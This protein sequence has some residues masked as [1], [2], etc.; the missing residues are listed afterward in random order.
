MRKNEQQQR[1]ERRQQERIDPR[2]RL[3]TPQQ[4]LHDAVTLIDHVRFDQ[5][6]CSR[7]RFSADH[8]PVITVGGSYPGFLSAF[9]RV[10]FPHVV[11][12]AYAASAPMAFYAQTVDR[13]A[14]YDHITHVADLTLPGCARAVRDSLLTVRNSILGSDDVDPEDGDFLHSAAVGVCPGTVPDYIR[15]C[16][17]SGDDGDDGDEDVI[18]DDDGDDDARKRRMKLRMA[19]ELMMVVGYTFANDN[20]ADYPPGTDTRLYRACQTFT[21][22]HLSAEERV[23]TFLVERLNHTATPPAPSCWN[24]SGQLPS[25]PHATISSGDWSGV[26]TGPNGE[27]WDFQTCTLLVEAIAF[28]GRSM[29]PPR[30]WTMG[31]LDRHCRRRFGGGVRPRP[32]DLVRRYGFDDLVGRNVTRILFTN[33]LRDGWSVAGIQANLSDTLVALNFP[34][35]AHHSDLSHAGPT[36]TD[37]DDIKEGY[38]RI[39]TILSTWLDDVRQGQHDDDAGR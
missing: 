5:L 26:G 34:N 18:G 12:M 22:Q 15:Y 37:T 7:D 21:S 16:C 35:G 29:F 28:S 30:E 27:S 32:H 38:G 8:C 23:K 3:F 2:V 17:P 24:M 25:G 36:P 4:A 9:A 20:M 14:Y 31:W 1:Q 19:E 13:D 6:G 39:V 33:G 11:D 10:L